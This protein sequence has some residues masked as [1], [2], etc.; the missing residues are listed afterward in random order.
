MTQFV[1]QCAVVIGKPRYPIETINDIDYLTGTRIY[2]VHSR[3]KHIPRINK[4]FGRQT[5]CIYTKK[6]QT[7]G[8]AT[9]K[10]TRTRTTK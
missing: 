3:K 1:Q 6:T 9:T 5:Q 10:K 2:K 4:I 8:V 7:T